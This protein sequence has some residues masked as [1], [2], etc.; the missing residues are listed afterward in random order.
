MI[1]SVAFS[2]HDQVYYGECAIVTSGFYKGFVGY[3]WESES[4]SV[5]LTVIKELPSGN[6][7]KERISVSTGSVQTC[8]ESQL[9]LL[10]EIYEKWDNQ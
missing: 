3:A 9:A 1:L 6:L 5:T 10:E 4:L 8:D 2:S 7:I